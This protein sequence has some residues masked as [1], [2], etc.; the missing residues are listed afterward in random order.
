MSVRT[1]QRG[2][3]LAAAA[4]ILFWCLPAQAATYFDFTYV[5]PTSGSPL[6]YGSGTFEADFVAGNQYNVTG[7]TGTAN[8]LTILGLSSYAGADQ[9]LYFPT[10][11]GTTVSFSGISFYTSYASW[12]LGNTGSN[13]GVTNSVANPNGYCCGWNPIN[14]TVSLQQEGA[15]GTTPLPGTLALFLSG[16]GLF[17]LLTS[18][19]KRKQ[20]TLGFASA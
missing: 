12:G 13:F 3:V 14:L 1:K 8:G 5:Y 19:R 15:T 2:V 9:Q 11:P 6:Y 10:P 4:A 16:T 17:G 7:I 18:W 20:G